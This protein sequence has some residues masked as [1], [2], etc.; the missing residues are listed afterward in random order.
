MVVAFF[1]IMEPDKRAEIIKLAEKLASESQIV[2]GHTHFLLLERD[3]DQRRDSD[4][5]DDNVPTR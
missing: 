1:C 5:N 4:N 3:A 2:E